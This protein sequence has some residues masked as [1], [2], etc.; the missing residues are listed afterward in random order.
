M[1]EIDVSRFEK[2]ITVRRMRQKDIPQVIELQKKCFPDMSPWKP[3]QLKNHLKVFPEG[4]FV[5]EHKGKVVGSS[6]SLIVDFDEYD[7]MHSF[8]DITA[9]GTISNHD[10]EGENL[11]GIEVMVDPDYRNM[12]VGGRLYD[13]RRRL[14][15]RLNLKS[16]IIAG[17]MPG[18]EEVANRMSPSQYVR[19][20]REKKIYDPVLT[21]QM[22]N[23]FVVKR[24]IPDYLPRDGESRGNAVL[25]EWPNIDYQPKLRRHLKTSLPVRVC[26]I[27]YQMRKINGF[28]DFA[29]QCEYFVDVAS[30]YDSDF[31][32]F[33]ELLTTQLLSFLEE[34]SPYAA[35][36]EL[37]AF[38]DQ[39]V[40]L[41]AGLAV[42]YNINII[43]GTHFIKGDGEGEGDDLYNV[44]FLFKRDGTIEKQYKI[45]VTNNERR[46]WGTRGGDV[47][48]VF[49]TD[50]GKIGIQICYDVEFPEMSRIQTEMGARLI[51]VPFCT[52]DRQGYLRVRNC[53]Q[54]RAIENQVYTVIAGT[55]G[56]L[57]DTENMDVQYAESAV[58][59]PSDFSFPRDG[60]AGECTPNVETVIVTDLDLEVLRR[61]RRSGTVMQ[62]RDRRSDL[63]ALKVSKKARGTEATE[64]TGPTTQAEPTRTQQQHK[65][66]SGTG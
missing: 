61:H 28:E 42:S 45:H 20:V 34:K 29:G 3:E 48:R 22:N 62:L 9:N 13:T 35:A 60:I 2:R 58:F 33:P 51:F 31:A 44:A 1:Q 64:K 19:E 32:V 37:A 16:I 52:E 63:Y 12:R 39:Y 4:Q 27:Q 50:K 57:P 54:A 36:R 8:N 7:T 11:Y 41:F 47:V 59:T 38:T 10:P 23:E 30:N 49:N 65:K 53:A 21:F 17:R 55:V 66:I 56:N 40:E 18:Y 5:V 26:V 15:E 25:M 14:A 46:W 24:V 6:S 43:A